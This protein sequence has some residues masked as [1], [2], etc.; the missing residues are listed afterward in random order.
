[1]FATGAFNLKEKQKMVKVKINGEEIRFTEAVSIEELLK[2]QNV[3]M[4]DMVTVEHNNEIL[5]RDQ[6]AA[7][8]IQE[9]DEIEFLYYMGGGGGGKLSLSNFTGLRARLRTRLR[10][11][12][13]GRG[14]YA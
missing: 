10:L 5:S 7:V 2:I 11:S 14:I 9:G 6:F 12:E 8:R 1:M 3:K 13:K 4:P